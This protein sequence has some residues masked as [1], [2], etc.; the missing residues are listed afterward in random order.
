MV[1][2]I[3]VVIDLGDPRKDDNMYTKNQKCEK[4]RSRYPDIGE[5]EIDIKTA[6]PVRKTT[7]FI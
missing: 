1:Y 3:F 7:L 6:W 4:I 5:W 2:C